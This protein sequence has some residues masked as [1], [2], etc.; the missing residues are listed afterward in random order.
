MP[1]NSWLCSWGFGGVECRIVF[2]LCGLLI[3]CLELLGGFPSLENLFG[4]RKIARGHGARS[5]GLMERLEQ[6]I[7][8]RMQAGSVKK[9]GKK[10]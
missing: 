6:G 2:L 9:K 10:S 4:Q 1:K 7:Y 5:L 8:V 3:F